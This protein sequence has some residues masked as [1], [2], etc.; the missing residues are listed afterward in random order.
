MTWIGDS[1]DELEGLIAHAQVVLKIL[2][3]QQANEEK[4]AR[5]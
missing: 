4:G 1:I 5:V 3:I 2:K